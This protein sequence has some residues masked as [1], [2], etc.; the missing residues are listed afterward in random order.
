MRCGS[1]RA[2]MGEC[3][4]LASAIAL[5]GGTRL[6]PGYIPVPAARAV[7]A[8][9]DWLPASV[10]QAAPLTTSRLDS[11]TH[12]RMY[13]VSRARRLLGF[14]AATDLPTGTTSAMRWYREQGLIRSR[15]P[16]REPA[17]DEGIPCESRATS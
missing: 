14:A 4:Y 7:A 8:V 10:R 13:D 1:A 3:F 15:R 2:A 16:R 6:P 12:S 5:A 11:L 17:S 9:G